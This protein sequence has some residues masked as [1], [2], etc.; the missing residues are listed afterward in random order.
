MSPL[1]IALIIIFLV[2]MLGLL[3]VLASRKQSG[4]SSG[5]ARGGAARRNVPARGNPKTLERINNQLARNPNNRNARLTLAT[6]YYRNRKWELAYKHYHLL[7][8]TSFEPRVRTEEEFIDRVR[9]GY[10]AHKSGKAE[11]AT[12]VMQ[13]LND[14]PFQNPTYLMTYGY[15]FYDRKEYLKALDCFEYARLQNQN[16][17]NAIK[18][19]AYCNYQLGSHSDTVRLLEQLH[20]KGGGDR[21]SS[22]YLIQ[23]YINRGQYA[24]G[25][26]LLHQLINSP[27][28]QLFA[29][30]NLGDIESKLRNNAEAAKHYIASLE[31][32]PEAESEHRHQVLYKLAHIYFNDDESNKAVAALKQIVAVDPGFKDADKLIRRYSQYTDKTGID[33]FLRLPSDTFTT[34]CMQIIRAYFPG[35]EAK[36]SL[37]SRNRNYSDFDVE[38]S[39]EHNT[40]IRL[41]RIVRS[42]SITGYSLVRDLYDQIGGS[43]YSQAVCISAGDFS[44]TARHLSVGRA[45]VL[46]GRQGLSQLLSK[47][48]L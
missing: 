5:G 17:S 46:I 44:S 8:S 35:G 25:T 7:F 13:T 24:K 26:A 22:R 37:T 1:E 32:I 27:H 30:E 42:E 34:V 10:S 19:A 33:R 47:I 41:V 21:R 29:L 40:S 4:G 28:D 39:S 23:S 9:Y 48:K 43:G 45:L 20:N 31:I 11:V 3:Y 2:P 38:F 6:A 15:I 36:C 18:Y 16:N 12:Q 14:W